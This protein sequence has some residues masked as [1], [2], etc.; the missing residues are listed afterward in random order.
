MATVIQQPGRSELFCLYDEDTGKLLATNQNDRDARTLLVSV[1]LDRGLSP[2]GARS[3]TGVLLAQARRYA[4]EGPARDPLWQVVKDSADPGTRA[5]VAETEGAAT[6]AGRLVTPATPKPGYPVRQPNGRYAVYTPVW[7]AFTAANLTR[8]AAQVEMVAIH[9]APAAAPAMSAADRDDPTPEYAPDAPLGRRRWEGALRAAAL[10]KGVLRNGP[11]S[12][13]V[14]EV[15]RVGEA[16]PPRPGVK[17]TVGWVVARDFQA[18][19]A[20]VREYLGLRTAADTL[21]LC[22]QWGERAEAVR[23][24]QHQARAL[25]RGLRRQGGGRAGGEAV[26]VGGNRLTPLPVGA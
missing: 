6:Y 14:D 12:L 4:A 10:G 15:R 11:H 9:G 3:R 21:D 16:P 23:L 1:L 18:R 8:E 7:A 13:P 2:R 22:G 17:V 5:W 19:G 25:V 26:A 24:P 20:T